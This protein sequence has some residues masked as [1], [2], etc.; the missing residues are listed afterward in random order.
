MVSAGIFASVAKADDTGYYYKT[1]NNHSV[2]MP[3][4]N[5]F[6][7]KVHDYFRFYSRATLPD[8]T[9]IHG[10]SGETPPAAGTRIR[11]TLP[12]DY[13]SNS[14][15]NAQR[16]DNN[17]N[18]GTYSVDWS[19]S[20][21]WGRIYRTTIN[22][23]D[24]AI[25]GSL[26]SNKPLHDF[27]KS[28]SLYG[29][30]G[31]SSDQTCT[32]GG[33]RACFTFR[34]PR[35]GTSASYTYSIRTQYG[36]QNTPQGSRTGSIT[37]SPS[38]GNMAFLINT[39]ACGP[40]MLC[41]DGLDNDGDGLIDML[42][43]GCTN[44]DDN[45]EQPQCS[46][47]ADNDGDGKYDWDGAGRGASFVDPG[48]VDANDDNETDPPQCSDTRDNDGDGATDFPAD[49]GCIDASDDNETNQPQCS[50]TRDN[51]GDGKTDFPNDPGCSAAD[52]DDETD[53]PACRDGN[54]ND[55]DGAT[56][57]PADLGCSSP[58]DPTEDGPW[59]CNDG[60]D[61]DGDT[62]IDFG[63]AAT[64]DPGCASA[65][66]DNEFNTITIPPPSVDGP[67]AGAPD[68]L[69]TFTAQSAAAG[70]ANNEYQYGFD[71]DSDGNVDFWTTPPV[72]AGQLGSASF[73]WTTVGGKD[74]QV[75]TKDKFGNISG[76]STPHTITISDTQDCSADADRTFWSGCP[77][78]CG[79]GTETEVKINADCS[80]TP[81]GNTRTCN[82]QACDSDFI[83]VPV[84]GP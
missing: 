26:S 74:F 76:W 82:A 64:N 17:V 81:T 73:T 69:Y 12:S 67:R 43:P 56:D 66:D 9:I 22:S 48:C 19:A 70:P 78:S 34:V 8:G 31:T 28:G 25:Y 35:P 54:D 6:N 68:T 2:T 77:V 84:G 13:Y 52:D 29:C 65:D 36:A 10:R 80:V 39:N 79:G 15:W 30:S 27:V 60:I 44:P 71:W 42:D 16:A 41:S 38:T 7:F 63:S 45:N 37:T 33:G 83:E 14:T 47:D 58:D 59:Q 24:Y 18:L 75:K 11:F 51:D 23:L 32:Y 53:V 1:N 61:N 72:Q 20:S 40:Y 5:V 62:L 3:D 50:D 57:H 55:G 49:P 4:G 46:D 21:L